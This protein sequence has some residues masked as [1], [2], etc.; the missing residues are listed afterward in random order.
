MGTYVYI[1]RHIH[2]S[3]NQYKI[4]HYFGDKLKKTKDADRIYVVAKQ[5]VFSEKVL[6]S[7]NSIIDNLYQMLFDNNNPITIY[8]DDIEEI[9]SDSIEY[10]VTEVEEHTLQLLE[11]IVEEHKYLTEGIVNFS[12]ISYE[13]S[14]G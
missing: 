12:D 7:N 3:E 11:N 6:S 9:I 8:I 1:E 14:V 13:L 4:S 10:G 5:M 2:L